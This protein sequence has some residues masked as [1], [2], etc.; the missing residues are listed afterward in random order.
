VSA[1]FDTL[2]LFFYLITFTLVNFVNVFDFYLQKQ[3][4]NFYN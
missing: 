3:S 1:D 4:L 2:V